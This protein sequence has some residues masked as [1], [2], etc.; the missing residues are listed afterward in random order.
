MLAL[1]QGGLSSSPLSTLPS[2]RFLCTFYSPRT[3]MCPL[4]TNGLRSL[5]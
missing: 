5:S 2:P 3:P 1:L 4:S